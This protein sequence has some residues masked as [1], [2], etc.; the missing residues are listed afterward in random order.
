M[1]KKKKNGE[2]QRY[3]CGTQKKKKNG[4][5][6]RSS[7]GAQKKMKMLCLQISFDCV[8]MIAT[9]VTVHTDGQCFVSHPVVRLP[10][11]QPMHQMCIIMCVCMFTHVHLCM[12]MH[13]TKYECAHLYA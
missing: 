6:Q 9:S 7:W 3:S 13:D 2:P 5:P 12:H 1:Q 8:S 11:C 10:H 4:E